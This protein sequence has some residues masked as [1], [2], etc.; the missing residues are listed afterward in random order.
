MVLLAAA[1]LH[2][3]YAKCLGSAYWQ[4]NEGIRKVITSLQNSIHLEYQA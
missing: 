4:R 3:V 1:C 2:L